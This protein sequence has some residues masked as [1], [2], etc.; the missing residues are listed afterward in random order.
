MNISRIR[1]IIQEEIKVLKELQI[2][3]GGNY[4]D[5]PVKKNEPTKEMPKGDADV[6]TKQKPQQ[7]D[8][9][10]EYIT[11]YTGTIS[12][13]VDT[14]IDKWHYHIKKTTPT[15]ID[16]Q[17]KKYQLTTNA[18]A[19][20]TVYEFPKDKLVDYAFKKVLKYTEEFFKKFVVKE[21]NNGVVITLPGGKN[22][23]IAVNNNSLI[24]DLPV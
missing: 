15:M 11:I 14:V 16:F 1:Q 8:K 4:S 23:S 7:D 5:E 9:T 13:I 17:Q 10:E 18:T 12:D 19:N 6:K 2:G 3:D 21:T 20:K 22:I 24:I